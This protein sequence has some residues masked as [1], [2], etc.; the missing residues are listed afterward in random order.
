MSRLLIVLDIDGTVLDVDNTIP[1]GTVRE[2]TR[3]RAAGHEVMLA[4]GRSWYDTLP[5]HERLGLNSR[6]VVSANG[7][8]TLERTGLPA[9]PTAPASAEARAATSGRG[10]P[11]SPY[12]PKWIE[13]FDPTDVLIRIHECIGERR[14]HYAVETPEGEFLYAG[15][16]PDM[17]FEAVGRECPFEELLHIEATRVV[18]V[19]PEHTTEEFMVIVDGLGLHQVSYSV[20]WT[21]WLDIAP[22][23][24]NKATA[25]ERVRTELGIAPDM[26]VAAGDGRN[27]LEMLRWAGRAGRSFAMGQASD[28]VL[29]AA[30]HRTG[31]FAEGG[32]AQ[33]LA[34][35]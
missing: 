1:E 8:F 27:D 9:A 17:A 10:I 31:T 34:T 24:V 23:G 32:L 15:S 14:A 18:V 16:F 30:T 25:L 12:T 33:A 21:S 22:H 13:T 35:L 26:L 6:F 2:V 4:T 20:G 5:I 3:L 28:D 29:A 7:A 19:S 11:V